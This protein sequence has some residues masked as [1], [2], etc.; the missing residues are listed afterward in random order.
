MGAHSLSSTDEITHEDDS[1]VKSTIIGWSTT[2]P[3]SFTRL[4]NDN[5][6]DE[7]S[8]LT[9]SILAIKERTNMLKNTILQQDSVP[10]DL[11][12]RCVEKCN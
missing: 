4:S 1:G 7:I 5:Q 6:Q 9:E 2:S 8:N 12:V 3:V 10:K 11:G